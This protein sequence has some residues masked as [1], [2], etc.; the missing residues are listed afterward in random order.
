MNHGKLIQQ[1]GRLVEQGHDPELCVQT[2]NIRGDW[3]QVSIPKWYPENKYRVALAFVEGK[4]VFEGD[5][6][7]YPDGNYLLAA[8]DVPLSQKEGGMYDLSWNPPKPKTVTIEISGECA[9]WLIDISA[10]SNKHTLELS[11]AAKKALENE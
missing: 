1:F 11:K 9:E 4:P 10:L 2:K 7:Y 6:L 8:I 3:Y 5:K